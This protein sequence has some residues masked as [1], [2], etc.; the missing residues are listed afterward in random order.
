MAAGLLQEGHSTNLDFIEER[1]FGLDVG[2]EGDEEGNELTEVTNGLLLDEVFLL[3]PLDHGHGA[4][5]D[6]HDRVLKRRQVM[7]IRL[8]SLGETCKQDLTL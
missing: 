7:I 5:P 6:H 2:G 4:V 1:E 3:V 8:L